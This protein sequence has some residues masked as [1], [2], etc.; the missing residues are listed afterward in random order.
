MPP[1]PPGPPLPPDRRCEICG[2]GV[3]LNPPRVPTSPRGHCPNPPA[4]NCSRT[5]AF[6]RYRH[7]WEDKE[8][9]RK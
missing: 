7:Y 6:G 8:L 5:C 3:V 4:L 1:P 2:G 9:F